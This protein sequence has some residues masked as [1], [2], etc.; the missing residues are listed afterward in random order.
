MRALAR[1]GQRAPG[2]AS[3]LN[4]EFFDAFAEWAGDP[5]KDLG[6]R[7]RSE[8]PLGVLRSVTSRGAFPQ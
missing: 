8:A 5:N 4:P 2:K 7:V 3:G 6:E 1:L